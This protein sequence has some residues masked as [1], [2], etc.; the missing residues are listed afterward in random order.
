[1][2]NSRPGHVELQ[3]W[4]W[5]H[6]APT[7]LRLPGKLLNWADRGQ[8]SIT[9]LNSK[10]SS[11]LLIDW[12]V[13]GIKSEMTELLLCRYYRH[14][15]MLCL[16]DEMEKCISSSNRH[17]GFNIETKRNLM[18]LYQS[19]S[20]RYCGRDRLPNSFVTGMQFNKLYSGFTHSPIDLSIPRW[21]PILAM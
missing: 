18:Q 11:W 15:Y 14:Q 19:W 8:L 13:L 21:H 4:V 7:S 10:K 5:A 16:D 6:T 9:I 2:L 12:E 3:L 20:R 1:M 17:I